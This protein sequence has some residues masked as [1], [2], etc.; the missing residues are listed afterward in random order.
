MTPAISARFST[1]PTRVFGRS[2]ITPRSFWLSGSST[3][4]EA[5]WADDVK[6]LL[7]AEMA[8]RGV[9]YEHLAEKLAADRRGGYGGQSEEQ[10]R[11]WPILCRLPHS[12]SY[13]IERT[14]APPKRRC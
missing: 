4:T 6:Q 3:K 2:T 11:P 13:G 8:R 5:E 7:R 9:T 1:K 10:G 12:V 14:R